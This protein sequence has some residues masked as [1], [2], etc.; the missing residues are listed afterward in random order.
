MFQ[1]STGSSKFLFFRSL[2]MRSPTVGACA[3]ADQL[4]LLTFRLAGCLIDISENCQKTSV[5]SL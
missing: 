3:I 4:H 2:R 5:T 1:H